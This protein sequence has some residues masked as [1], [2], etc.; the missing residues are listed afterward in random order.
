VRLRGLLLALGIV[1]C[2]FAAISTVSVEV[3]VVRAGYERARLMRLIDNERE[4]IQSCE[5]E[6]ADAVVPRVLIERAT[7]LGLALIERRPSQIIVAPPPEFAETQ[8][9]FLVRR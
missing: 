7:R 2:L 8:G 6:I 1:A 4:L 3:E 9:P 5:G